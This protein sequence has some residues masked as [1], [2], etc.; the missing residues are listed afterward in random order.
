MSGWNETR[1]RFSSWWRPVGTGR[2]TVWYT[3]AG[4]RWTLF[5]D[6]KEPVASEES[7]DTAGEAM[8]AAERHADG[9]AD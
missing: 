8:A 3:G 7:F 1:G 4:W 9:G 2:V 5:R 6:G